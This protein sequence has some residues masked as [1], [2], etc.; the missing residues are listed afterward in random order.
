MDRKLTC[1]VARTIRVPAEVTEMEMHRVQC[2]FTGDTPAA[3]FVRRGPERQTNGT[4]KRKQIGHTQAQRCVVAT[5]H[6]GDQ[7]VRAG[8]PQVRAGHLQVRAG[9]LCRC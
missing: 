9:H 6:Q 5:V 7:S 4:H 1:A 3:L 2:V 8:H